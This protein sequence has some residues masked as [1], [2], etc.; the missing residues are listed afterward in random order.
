MFG[1]P[2]FERHV[3]VQETTVEQLER[4]AV[5]DIEVE[6]GALRDGPAAHALVKAA[7]LDAATKRVA[8]TEPGLFATRHRCAA[9]RPEEKVTP[10]F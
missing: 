7:L 2:A 9:I 5:A 10:L 3:R 4:L 6:R 8:A 1:H